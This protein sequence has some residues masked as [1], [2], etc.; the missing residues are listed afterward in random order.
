ME[1]PMYC[2]V[3]S[4]SPTAMALGP[5]AWPGQA[6]YCTSVN[7]SL[8]NSSSVMN[9]GARQMLGAR[10]S[11]TLVTSGGGSALAV[12]GR[13]P[14]KPAVPPSASAFT[15]SRR[16]RC[17]AE[18][19]LNHLIRPQQQRRWDGEAEGLSCLEVNKQ[20][21]LGRLLDRKIAWFRASEDLVDEER[22]T[23]KHLVVVRSIGHQTACLTELPELRN[24]REPV[25]GSN[26]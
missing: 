14:S 6:R 16:L 9:C 4:A 1:G 10:N 22:G 19:L 15:N 20:L 13:I 7:P 26:L 8:R 3:M 2:I 5:S 21:E 11:R 12:S 17:M 23:A 25:F 18:L 24:Y